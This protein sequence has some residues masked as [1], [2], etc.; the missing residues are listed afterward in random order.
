LQLSQRGSGASSG[1]YAG[2]PCT[3]PDIPPGETVSGRLLPALIA[4]SGPSITT[5]PR[6]G[7]APSV[8]IFLYLVS[9]AIVAAV[10]IGVFFGVAFSLLR[11]PANALVAEWLIR[12]RGSNIGTVPQGGLPRGGGAAPGNSDTAA[13]AA[14]AAQQVPFTAPAKPGPAT[15]VAGPAP[16]TG[17]NMPGNAGA[18]IAVAPRMPDGQLAEFLSRGDVFLRAGDIASARLF[19]ERAA[20]AGDGQAALRMGATFDPTFL[21]SVGLRNVP[22]D[23]DRARFWFHRALS[24]GARE[25]EPHL[26]SLE[27]K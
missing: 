3:I 14:K 22:G 18:K 11:Q 6:R 2:I 7:F 15:A 23:L 1:F 20:D 24:L 26:N 8:G 17:E 12:G 21:A 5:A 10:T 13:A 9:V 16:K 27:T 25:A 19:Y 4:A